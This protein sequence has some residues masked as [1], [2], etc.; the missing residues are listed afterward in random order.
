VQTY[1][2]VIHGDREGGYWAE[3][4]ALPGCYSQGESVDELKHN[5]SEAIAG[6]P[7][8]LR[9][10]GRAPDSNSKIDDVVG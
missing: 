10:E 8:V 4:P 2:V 1:A 7:R 3:V 5:I 9:E 6:V